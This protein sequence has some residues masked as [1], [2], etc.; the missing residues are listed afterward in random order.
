MTACGQRCKTGHSHHGIQAL[1]GP[2]STVA[3]SPWKTLHV[4]HIPTAPTNVRVLLIRLGLTTVLQHH[5]SIRKE[6]QSLEKAGSSSGFDVSDEGSHWLIC[7]PTGFS[8]SFRKTMDT[9]TI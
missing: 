3:H 7:I 6:W 1:V 8:S 5:R 4:S 2:F 9:Y